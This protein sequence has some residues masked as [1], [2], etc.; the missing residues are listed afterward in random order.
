MQIEIRLSNREMRVLKPVCYRVPRLKRWYLQHWKN[1]FGSHYV[2]NGQ[3][4]KS[5][6]RPDFFIWWPKD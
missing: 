2:I 3:K 1:V 4:H 5:Q 6:P